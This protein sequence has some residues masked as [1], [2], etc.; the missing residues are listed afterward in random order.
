MECEKLAQEKTE[1][2]RHYVMVGAHCD[3]DLMMNNTFFLYTIGSKLARSID[4]QARWNC[5]IPLFMRTFLEH[6]SKAT[7]NTQ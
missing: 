6:I 5:P 3:L 7:V 4:R 1:M 2:Q